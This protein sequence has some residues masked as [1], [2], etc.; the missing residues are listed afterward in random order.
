M[1]ARSAVSSPDQERVQAGALVQATQAQPVVE[2]LT[3]ANG[4]RPDRHA[5]A[6]TE[7]QVESGQC[8]A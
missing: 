1:K 7:E 6:G 4:I 5:G 2:A 3:G 8:D